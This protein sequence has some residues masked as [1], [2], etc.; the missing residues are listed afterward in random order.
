MKAI[1]TLA[2]VLLLAIASHV[3]A[4]IDSGLVAA[5]TFT[6]DY[7]DESGNSFHGTPVNGPGFTRDRFNREY[8]ALLLSGDSEYVSIPS[9]ININT[10]MTI[11]FWIRTTATD[12]D[13]FYFG[14]FVIDRDICNYM[15]DWDI[16]MG[17]G[18][19][20]I[21]TTGTTF[22][23][24]SMNTVKDIND[25]YWHHILVTLSSADNM[26]RIYVDR[27]LNRSA[28]FNVTPFTNNYLPIYIGASVCGPEG[29]DFF[30]GELD[31]IRFYNRTIS[32]D[33]INRL[34]FGDTSYVRVIPQGIYDSLTNRL[35]KK[36]TIDL[37]FHK[38][39]S[40]VDSA[41]AVIDS[42]SFIAPFSI[43]DHF[44]ELLFVEVK[45][46]NSFHTWSDLKYIDYGTIVYDFTA[47]DWASGVNL[48]RVDSNP[49]RYG[50]YSGDVN[51]DNTIDAADAAI[52][53][54]DVRNLVTGYAVTDL[55]GDFI[56]DGSDF[57]IVDDNAF[58][59]ISLPVYDRIFNSI[60]IDA[61]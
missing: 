39:F 5:Y 42:V 19:K 10:D 18:G 40:I 46:R 57:A 54:N 45:H 49:L 30:K 31:D 50:M 60:I 12:P 21:F 47:R 17:L 13:P 36:D 48:I 9:G 59:M 32:S 41:T 55:N 4:N 44:G 2:A 29:H 35:T 37:Y 51:S 1:I 26:K 14:M 33:D 34:Y 16:S 6:R 20:M 15:K 8:S 7:L 3:N 53:D 24:Q 52:I 11:S 27:I 22:G 56:V 23:D 28:S 43:G 25:G 38:Y 58:R 61:P